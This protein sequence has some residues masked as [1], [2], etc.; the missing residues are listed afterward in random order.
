MFPKKL[1]V[2]AALMGAASV[3][4]CSC[5]SEGPQVEDS[6][7]PG[8][9]EKDGGN[10]GGEDGGPPAGSDAGRDAGMVVVIPTDPF[11]P[12]NVNRDTDCD[13]LTDQEEYASVYAGGKKTLPG[14][15]DTD[16][17]GIKDGVELGRTSSLNTACSF[18]G[19]ADM[20]TR[21]VPTELDS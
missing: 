4:G 5:G 6:G 13:G 15:A 10:P 19:D 8:T 18:M 21:T 9:G 17:D 20:A 16:G 12:D 1:L 2:I 11:N 14:V 3:A 7:P